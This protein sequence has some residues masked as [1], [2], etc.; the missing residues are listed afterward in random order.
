M[1]K[2]IVSGSN[3]RTLKVWDTYEVTLKRVC[4]EEVDEDNEGQQHKKHAEECEYVTAVGSALRDPFAKLRV[5]PE[6]AKTDSAYH[7]V[8]I[9]NLLGCGFVPPGRYKMTPQLLDALANSSAS[10]FY[11]T[12]VND[13]NDPH[14]VCKQMPPCT[15]CSVC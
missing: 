12:Y 4:P 8:A 5:G 13:Y 2:T 9:G 15:G 1:R 6:Y 7:I 14:F 3:D 11:Y 10:V